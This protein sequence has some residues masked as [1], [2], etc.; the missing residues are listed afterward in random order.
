MLII[1]ELNIN[2]NNLYESVTKTK[3]NLFL[4][5]TKK[6]KNKQL[7]NNNTIYNLEKNINNNRNEKIKIIIK[8]LEHNALS[9][10][11]INILTYKIHNKEN[12]KK[13]KKIHE[14]YKKYKLI[15]SNLKINPRNNIYKRNKK[16][17]INFKKN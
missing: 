1:N 16:R 8:K 3:N 9:I 4:C 12:K 5:S 14:N 11:D 13:I 17:L 6:I 7:K 2:N 10:K 15:C